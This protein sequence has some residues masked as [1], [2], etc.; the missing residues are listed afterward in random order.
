MTSLA[1]TFSQFILY[2]FRIYFFLILIYVIM[3]WVPSLRNT[4]FGQ[5]VEKVVEPY[6]GFFR[7][8]IPPI[9]MIDISVIFAIIALQFIE[10]GTRTVLHQLILFTL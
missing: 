7:K 9:G 6:L 10:S 1:F 8:F 2:G 4:T 5:L 3:S